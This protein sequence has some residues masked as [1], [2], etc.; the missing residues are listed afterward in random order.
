MPR[1]GRTMRQE[2]RG[3]SLL[4]TLV[5][6]VSG[7]IGV[8]WKAGAGTQELARDKAAC[9]AE[10]A[11]AE[12]FEACMSERGW[13]HS[14][15]PGV[16]RVSG[17]PTPGT[18]DPA[19]VPASAAR[20]SEAVDSS[21][22]VR[23]SE[24][25]SGSA[26]EP[27]LQP[28]AG[29]SVVPPAGAAAAAAAAATPATVVSSPAAGATESAGTSSGV[30]WKFGASA[31]ELERDQATCLEAGGLRVEREA[32]PRWGESAGFDRC[33]C[34]RGWRGGPC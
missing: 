11:D 22:R 16:A 15:G 34:A 29:R 24:P 10:V 20:N 2:L 7:C 27:A 5:F 19:A 1:T 3:A 12:G 8:W 14:P 32:G 21:A 26:S 28:D 17:D 33:M 4:L 31:S 25:V 23:A 30:F 13:W 6:L 18:R 9:R